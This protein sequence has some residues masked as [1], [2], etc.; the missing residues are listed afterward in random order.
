MGARRVLWEAMYA[1]L[2][3]GLGVGLAALLRPRPGWEDV[4]LPMQLAA[5]LCGLLCGPGYG[6]SCGVLCPVVSHLVFGVPGLASL[7]ERIV[8]L[9][10]YGF[11]AGLLVCLLHSGWGWINVYGALL[12]AMALG[13]CLEGLLYF[14]FFRN[15]YTL[16]DWLQGC[17]LTPLPGIIL[18]LAALPVAVLALWKLH[19]QLRPCG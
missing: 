7:P 19:P 8:V 5:V 4:L 6:L 13:R 15:G 1:F 3:V 10:L 17:F 16:W 9:G 14:C 2:C 12:A 18:Q 11:L